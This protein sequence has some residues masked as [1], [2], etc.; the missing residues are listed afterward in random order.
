MNIL[1]VTLHVSPSAQ[2]VALAAGNLKAALPASLRHR[3]RLVDLYPGSAPEQLCSDLLT[4]NPE[5]IAFPLYVW[6]R[7]AILQ[8]ARVLRQARPNLIMLAGGPE[9]SA[10]SPGVLAEGQLDAVIRGEG[11]EAFPELLQ[12]IHQRKSWDQIPGLVT[13]AL[14]GPL[15]PAAHCS[16]LERTTSPWLSGTLPLHKGCGVLWEVARGCQFNCAFCYDSK[17]QQGVRPLPFARLKAELELFRRQGVSQLWVLDSTFNAPPERG[18]QLLELL[19]KTAPGIHYHIEAKADFLDEQTAELLSR[20][21]CSVQIGLQS[22]DSRVLKPLHRSLKQSRVTRSLELL[23]NA[24]VTF[25]LDLIYGLPGDNH[26]G[27]QSSLDFA[28]NQQPNQ[29]DVFPLA[30]LPGTELFDNRQKFGIRSQDAPPY[31]LLENRSYS[32]DDLQES[33]RLAAATDI[34]YNR[35]RAVG[36]FLQLCQ[37][38][39]RTPSRL[40]TEFSHWLVEVKKLPETDILNTEAWWPADILPLQ[41]EFG[42]DLLKRCG[43]SACRHVLEDLI[44][45]HF[46]CAEMVLAANCEGPVNRQSGKGARWR[47]NPQIQVMRFHHPLEELEYYGGERLQKL[48]GILTREKEYVVFLRQNDE[49]MMEALEENF[50]IMLQQADGTRTYAELLRKHRQVHAEELDFAIAHGLL[51][52][53]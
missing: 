34:F 22:A 5:V 35:G 43:Q 45:Y 4:L 23:S 2:A 44:N 17:G 41:Q 37:V 46:V 26:A 30:V 14:P 18:R 8:T 19:L 39:K 29:V 42:A 38:S 7:T 1:I 11:E 10:D 3:T 28:L 15:P 36:F 25:G 48:A 20:L 27:F 52:P 49:V 12:R 21:S 16:D 33:R 32:T 6:N 24:G 51:I 53:A 31:A 9:A 50:A 40:L 13:S 47:R